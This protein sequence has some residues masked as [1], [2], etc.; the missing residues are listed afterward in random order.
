MWTIS[1]SYICALLL[2]LEKKHYC[3]APAKKF[4]SEK[5]SLDNFW[6]LA[7]CAPTSLLWPWKCVLSVSV[8]FHMMC[9][10]KRG[11]TCAYH[12]LLKLY[13]RTHIFLWFTFFCSICRAKE[14]KTFGSKGWNWWSRSFGT[15]FAFFLFVWKLTF[16]CYGI[17]IYLC[18]PICRYEK[19]IL[20]QEVCSQ[21]LRVCFLLSCGNTNQIWTILKANLRNLYL[22]TWTPLHGI[23]CWNQAWQMLWRYD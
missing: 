8:F 18:L 7:Y 4:P 12:L 17:L 15:F 20:R 23:F 22:V 16:F 1:L 14:A 9:I 6:R 13:T 10:K 5:F 21:T 11:I 3:I 2:S 19:W